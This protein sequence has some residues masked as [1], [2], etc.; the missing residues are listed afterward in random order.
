MTDIEMGS[1]AA[2]C[3]QAYLIDFGLCYPR[4]SELQCQQEM[5][6]L[7]AAFGLAYPGS[8]HSSSSGAWAVGVLVCCLKH[9]DLSSVDSYN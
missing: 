1:R 5:R 7:Y 3:T 9:V 2:T 8:R 4:P 6:Q